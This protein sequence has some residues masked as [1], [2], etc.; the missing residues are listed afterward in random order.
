MLL[1]KATFHKAYRA[2]YKREYSSA[3][4]V[5]ELVEEVGRELRCTGQGCTIIYGHPE[6]IS[7]AVL[8]RLVR[9]L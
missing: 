4:R 7:R 1:S 5:N 6:F 8:L 2:Q 9:F 3:G